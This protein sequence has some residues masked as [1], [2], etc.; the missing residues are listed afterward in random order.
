MVTLLRCSVCGK[1]LREPTTGGDHAV[2]ICVHCGISNTV[3]DGVVDRLRYLAARVRP[4]DEERCEPRCKKD[5]EYV[6]QGPVRL[7]REERAEYVQLV[8]WLCL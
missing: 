5:A 4:E 3:K 6:L 2:A 8:Y 1:D 7:E